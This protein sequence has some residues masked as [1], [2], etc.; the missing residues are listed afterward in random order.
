MGKSILLFPGQGS[1]YAGMGKAWA[2][3]A[4]NSNL[5]EVASD[6]MSLDMSK[7]IFDG[8]D[9]ELKKTEYTQ[10]SLFVVSAMAYNLLQKEGKPFHAVAGHSLGEYSALYA[11]GVLGFESALKI[12]KLRGQLMAEAGKIAPGAMSAV[13]GME[14]S[15]I[16]S[17]LE[18]VEG[19]VVSA[20]Y[21]SNA[22]V[23][24]SG[25]ISAIEEAE[26]QLSEKGAKK[27]VRLP[28]SGAFHS[29]LMQF[30][31]DGLKSE[32]E[33]YSFANAQVPLY[34]NVDAQPTQNSQ[35]IKEGLIQQITSPVRWVQT[36]ENCLANGFDS[37]I[38][39]GPGKVL[40]GL[41]RGISRDLKVAVAES[42]YPQSENVNG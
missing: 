40:M 13:L 20:N 11:A 29:P 39:V 2:D 4:E 21:N 12:V 24:I 22:Q 42:L 26:K 3:N 34:R 19:V 18:N 17:V 32:I 15:A 5:L 28:V 7:L 8:P 31:V 37:G 38:E 41:C 9:E 30:A 27:V 23:V 16:D 10:P 1:Q 6:I 14:P 25:E 36:V 33:K 35:D